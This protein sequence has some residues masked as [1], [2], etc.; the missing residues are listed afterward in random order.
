M[1]RILFTVAAAGTTLLATAQSVQD[2]WKAL[3]YGKFKSAKE[4]FEKLATAKPDDAAA[5]YWL[6]Q[7]YISQPEPDLA[8]ARAQ[9]AKAMTSTN[10]NPLIVAGMGHVEVLEGKKAEARAHFDAAVEATKSK[11]NKQFGDFEVLAAIGRANADGSSEQGDPDYGIQKLDQAAQIDEK[12]PDI[13]VSKGVSYLKKGGEFG[14]PAKMAFDAAIARDPNYARAYWRIGRIFESQ[15]NTPVMLENYEKAVQVDPEFAP[16]FLSLYNY[17][18]NRD[19]NKAKGYLESFIAKSDKD[20]ETDFFYADYLFR[21]GRY[22]ESLAKGQEINGV[23][24]ADKMPK[25]YNLFGL[26]YDRLGD[27]VKAKENMETYISKQP[28]DKITGDDYA[29]MAKLYLKFPADS[30]K[31]DPLITKAFDADTSK[32]GKLAIAKAAAEAF[33]TAKNFAGQYKWLD[34]AFQIKPDTSARN[35]YFIVTA[36]TQ[37][38]IFD[39]ADAYADRYINSYPDQ[40]QGYYLRTEA[41]KKADFDTSKGSAIPAIDQYNQFLVKDTAKNKS[42]IFNNIG[43]KIAYYANKKQDYPKALEAVNEILAIDPTNSYATQVKKQLEAAMNR[44][45]KPAGGSS[46]QAGGGAT[47][48][49][50]S[51][52]QP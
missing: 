29:Q 46:G 24:P 50:S 17:Y 52:K 32:D 27:S 23:C 28:A 3:Y 15:K 48:T 44:G 45:T 30:A 25:L 31:V 14:G 43:Y 16:A 13:L 39:G 51:G 21:A 40:V 33:A 11:K 10:Q 49:K 38:G 9:Y 26:N 2:G 22:Q 19:V 7:V 34:K 35:Y 42:R 8:A 18:S 20:C 36:A 5:N 41:A 37:A 47:G 6:G 1:K 12:N 4:I